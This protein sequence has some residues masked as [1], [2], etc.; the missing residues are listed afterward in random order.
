MLSKENHINEPDLLRTLA[1][2]SN[3]I[4]NLRTLVKELNFEVCLPEF[5]EEIRVSHVN[6]AQ[7][8]IGMAALDKFREVDYKTY[9]CTMD[10]M[11]FYSSLST[12]LYGNEG[13]ARALKLITLKYVVDN[14]DALE[15]VQAKLRKSKSVKATLRQC[16]SEE[17]IPNP[18]TIWCA[19]RALQIRINA[20]FLPHNG[21]ENQTYR[22]MMNAY[23]AGEISVEEKREVFILWSNTEEISEEDYWRPNHMVPMIRIFPEDL[24]QA[25]EDEEKAVEE[26]EGYSEEEGEVL[27]WDSSE[28]EGDVQEDENVQVMMQHDEMTVQDCELKM[29]RDSE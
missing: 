12:A 24:R 20:I 11:Y 28:E 23:E 3:D 18:L 19:A 10:G 22:D 6:L 13:Y 29:L 8:K 21:L 4:I 16:A 25:G 14:Y 27:P 9:E 7:C 15:Q 2:F 1:S 17:P 5:P 26:V